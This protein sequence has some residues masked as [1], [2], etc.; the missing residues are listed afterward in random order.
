MFLLVS[1]RHVGAH[2]DELQ[3]GV[4]IQSSINLGKTFPRDRISRIRINPLTQ[5]LARVFVYLHPFISQILS[6]LYLSNGFDFYFG[7]FWMAWHWKPATATIRCLNT[8]SSS[9][10]LWKEIFTRFSSYTF[11]VPPRSVPRSFR[12]TAILEVGVFAGLH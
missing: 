1:V 6:G 2:P 8:P 9:G 11:L 3:H 4:S 10:N 5:I 7:L 12:V